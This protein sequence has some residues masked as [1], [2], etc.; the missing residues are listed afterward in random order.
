MP[1]TANRKSALPLSRLIYL[2]LS[3]G[4]Q[5]ATNFL[6]FLLKYREGIELIPYNHLVAGIG[7]LIGLCRDSG[8][9]RILKTIVCQQ[10]THLLDNDDLSFQWK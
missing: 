1:I 6:Y 5:L 7:E 4:Q 8:L 9:E 10:F 3:Q 2:Q